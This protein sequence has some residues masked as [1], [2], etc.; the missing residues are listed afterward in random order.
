MYA[1]TIGS[2][3][4]TSVRTSLHVC[5]WGRAP[6]HRWGRLAPLRLGPCAGAGAGARRAPVSGERCV[7]AAASAPC[8]VCV[9]V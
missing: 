8:G 2:I 7:P 4:S 3:C 6:P 9:S 1:L 5:W